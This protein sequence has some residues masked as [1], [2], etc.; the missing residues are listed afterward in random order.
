[1]KI[2]NLAPRLFC[3]CVFVLVPFASLAG[4]ADKTLDIYWIDVEGGAGTLI[5][6]PE[7]ESVLIDTGMPGA[8]DSGR[9]YEAAT[10]AVGLKKLIT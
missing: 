10:K 2:G 7:N 6:T 4:M 1:M 8:R 5:V 9:I 3:L